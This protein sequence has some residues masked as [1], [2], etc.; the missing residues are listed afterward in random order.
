MS[1]VTQAEALVLQHSYDCSIETLFDA[2][3]DP[4]T[5]REFMA[6]GSYKVDRLEWDA[7]PGGAFLVEMRGE[8]EAIP[9]SGRFVEIRRPQRIVFTWSSIHAGKDTQVTLDFARAGARTLL[10]LTHER[11]PQ[12]KVEAHRGGWTAILA[13]LASARGA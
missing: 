12:Q 3:L 6:P 2:W 4:A 9:H 13:K 5:V 10:T 8:G 7:R 11:L 1:T